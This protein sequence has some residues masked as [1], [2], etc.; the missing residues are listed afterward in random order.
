MPPSKKQTQTPCEALFS[1]L[2]LRV[3]LVDS[4]GRI[5]YANPRA[6]SALASQPGGL[7]SLML[8]ALFSLRN[9][10]WL[11]REVCK[12]ALERHWS[13]EVMLTRLDGSEYWARIQASKCPTALGMG[14]AA[15]LEFEDI[16]GSVELMATLM[17]RNEELFQRNS[18]LEQR[19]RKAA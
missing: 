16:T 14:D 18:E 12:A 7:K 19:L 5:T 15:L 8:D 2:H 4:A 13:G 1:D 6:E 11:A 9:P 10:Q 3:L 17:R